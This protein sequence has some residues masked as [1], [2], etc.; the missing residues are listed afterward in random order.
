MLFGSA[1]EVD[2][3]QFEPR[4]HYANENLPELARYFR[5]MMWLGRMDLRLLEA[6]PDGSLLFR[7]RQLDG[8]LALRDAVDAA[9]EARWARVSGVVGAFVGAPDAMTLPE[10]ASLL[11]ALGVASAADVAA[12]PDDAVA[13]AILD[14]GF[15]EQRVAGQLMKVGPDVGTLPL[16]RSFAV[17]PQRYTLDAHVLTNVS[18][19]RVGGGQVKR[20]MPSPLDVAFAA[21]GNGEAGRLLAPELATYAYAP[22]LCAVRVLADAH[23]KDAFEGSLYGRWL[24]SLRALSPGPEVGAPTAAGLPT[25]AATEPWARRVLSAQLASWAELRHDTILYAKPSYSDDPACEFPDGYVDPYPAFYDAIAAFAADGQAMLEALDVPAATR[26][27]FVGYFQELGAVA[28]ALSDLAK[29]ELAKAPLT[30]EQHAFLNQAVKIGQDCADTVTETG[31]YGR[32]FFDLPASLDWDPTIADVHT[33]P[34]D[35][36]GVPVGRVLHVGTG[37]ARAMIVTV[38]ACDGPRAYVGLASSYFELVTE[39]YD[40]LTDARWASQ[41]VPT[42]TDPPWLAG[43]VVH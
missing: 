19:S 4:G 42:A 26:A 9:A 23:P 14:G 11:G 25:V 24:T 34:S 35:A 20:M 3:S 8:A 29:A 36:D 16:S 15:G 33:Q 22:D 31:W 17:F 13:Q 40:R 18:F 38:D 37:P 28:A 2:F 5:A 43:V 21:L 10:V 30:P 41:G 1:R 12:L 27:R 39:D 32:L 6:Q 7:R